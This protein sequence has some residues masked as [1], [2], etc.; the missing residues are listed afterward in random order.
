MLR[1]ALFTGSPWPVG[2]HGCTVLHKLVPLAVFILDFQ[3]PNPG[4][5]G[6]EQCL[7]A[8]CPLS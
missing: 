4:T 2:L 1:G 6:K 3:G 8:P 7:Y 5:T